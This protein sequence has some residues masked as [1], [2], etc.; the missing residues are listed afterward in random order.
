MS[1]DVY[2]E[3][4]GQCGERRQAIFIREDG[5]NKEIDRAEWDRRYPDREPVTAEIGGGQEVY[6]ANITHNL[7]TMA[8][9]AG[10]YQHLW[11][12]EEVGVKIAADLIGPLSDGLGALKKDP[13]KFQAFNPPNKWG[14]YEGL[15]TFV[16]QY[17]A[18][19][20]KYPTASVRA[21][22]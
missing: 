4:P 20:K 5:Q 10:I 1:L 11:R 15:V 7:N 14:D 17:L 13:E 8:D 16:E 2:L 19:C 21:S 6:S 9:A 12:P 3:L 22:R 18:A